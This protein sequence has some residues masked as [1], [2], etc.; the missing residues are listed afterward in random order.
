MTKE[1]NIFYVTSPF[2]YLCALE[3]VQALCEPDSTH[4]LV[5]EV[6]DTAV[7]MKQ[8]ESLI[9]QNQWHH[10]FRLTTGNR[11]INTP[12]VIREIKNYLNRQKLVV[13]Y[14]GYAEFTSW[15]IN[16]I[17]KNIA[18][19][20]PLYFDD[21]TLS[22][23]EFETFI[24]PKKP[25]QRTRLFNDLLLRLQGTHPIGSADFPKNL[26]LFSLFDFS[27]SQL[28]YV[29]NTF[30]ALK[31]RFEKHEIYRADAPIA[32]I[33]QGA[34]DH[35]NMKPLSIYKKEVEQAIQ[36]TH[37]NRLIYFPHRN[38]ENH[39][40]Q[41]I[42]S[43]EGVVY[44]DSIFPLEYEVLFNKLSFSRLIAPYSTALFSI[45]KLSPKLPITFLKEEVNSLG[46]QLIAAEIKR[47]NIADE[48]KT[49]F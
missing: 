34:I 2:Q 11:T 30:S 35:K 38:E 16:L 44:H 3:A 46:K 7:G 36:L 1:A 42:S 48:E 17:K 49:L 12:I 45:K 28:N 24:K 26:M 22:L 18:H 15:R 19:R 21:G 25:Y 27:N 47:Y 5:L 31:S 29:E 41:A 40:R 14:F 39:V 10:I 4:L 43:I 32:F 6:D 20:R 9:A 23:V 37:N 13:N 8:L 33:G